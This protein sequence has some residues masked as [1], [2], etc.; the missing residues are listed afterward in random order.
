MKNINILPL[1]A[2]VIA[3]KNKKRI[4]ATAKWEKT[5]LVVEGFWGGIAFAM[6]LNYNDFGG[7]EIEDLVTWPDVEL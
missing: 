7:L 4:F 1:V 5:G 6:L 2:G 3:A